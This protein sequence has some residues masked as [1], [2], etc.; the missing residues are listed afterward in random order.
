MSVNLQ[1]VAGLQLAAGIVYLAVAAMQFQLLQRAEQPLVIPDVAL[2]PYLQP[3]VAEQLAAGVVQTGQLELAIA[4]AED[5]T[6]AV[7]G[8]AGLQAQGLAANHLA[9]VVVDASG[10]HV[11]RLL[12]TQLALAVV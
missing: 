4:Q 6:A 10:L 7:A 11:Q 12:A 9:T 2:C 8:R 3:A 1:C 5:F